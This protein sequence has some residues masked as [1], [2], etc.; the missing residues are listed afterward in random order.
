M[1]TV[2]KFGKTS[3]ELLNRRKPN[4]EFLEP[5]EAPCTMLNPNEKFGPKAEE[6]YFVGYVT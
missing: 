2:K 5:F 6:G 3:Y 4:L 1:L